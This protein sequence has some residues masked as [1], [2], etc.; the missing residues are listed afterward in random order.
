MGLAVQ[1]DRLEVRQRLVGL[2]K[3]DALT[4]HEQLAREKNERK[5]SQGR[6]QCQSSRTSK[7]SKMFHICEEG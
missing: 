2:A 1:S 6:I 7:L 5:N 4:L 3:V